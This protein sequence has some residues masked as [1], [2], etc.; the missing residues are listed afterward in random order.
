MLE[1]RLEK[2]DEMDE[3]PKRSENGSYIGFRNGLKSN[4]KKET[5]NAKINP[6]V[7]N[8]LAT[9]LVDGRTVCRCRR[10]ITEFWNLFDSWNS[11]SSFSPS[12]SL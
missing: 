1:L 4:R 12:Y 6:A 3:W 5:T 11:D 9:G 7:V 8:I 2:A 10:A